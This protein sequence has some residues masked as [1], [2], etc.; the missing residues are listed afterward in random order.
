MNEDL[1][2]AWALEPTT[3]ANRALA[4]KLPLADLDPSNGHLFRDDS[5]GAYF[6]RLRREDPVH[7]CAQ[8]RFG[9]YWSVT[10]YRDIQAVEL[11]PGVF[12]SSAALGGIALSTSGLP[13]PNPSFITTD[14]PRHDEQRA[15]VNDA[16]GPARVARMES[17]IRD[18]VC[19]VLDALPIGE[20]FDWVPRVSIELTTHILAILFDFPREE[21][22]LLT[23]WSDIATGHPK[24]DGPVTS[25]EMRAQELQR[26]HAYFQ[27]LWRA[28]ADDPSGDD[29]LSMMARSPAM[30]ALPPD[31]FLG[32]LLLLI[33]GGNDTTRN[34]ITGGVL[35]LNRY[36]AEY[37]KLRADPGLVVSLVPEIIRWQTPLAHMARTALDDVELG[38]KTIRR[39]DRVA[40]WYLSANRDDSVIEEPE[41]LVIDRKSPR[42]HLSFGFGVHHCMGSRLAEA[43]LRVLWEELL[44][45]FPSIEVVAPPVRVMSNFVHGYASLPVLIRQRH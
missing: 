1:G 26:C 10:R 20:V 24:D 40:L 38:G 11:D 30:R 45:R 39:G 35:A 41:R 32:N 2:P 15:A 14:P 28:R 31:E 34:S 4:W 16:A 43:Q 23:W 18:R 36:P 6:E 3:L 37:D 9:P 44:R 21:R 33:V 29:L 12:S 19:E 42:R 22:R 13:D 8:S 17:L 25:W 7:Y 27:R 5:I